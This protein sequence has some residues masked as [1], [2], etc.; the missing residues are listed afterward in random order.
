MSKLIRRKYK[1]PVNNG[2]HKDIP[3]QVDLVNLT[4]VKERTP[5]TKAAYATYHLPVEEEVR[6]V[7]VVMRNQTKGSHGTLNLG[8]KFLSLKEIL[9][10]SKMKTRKG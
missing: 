8:G 3:F 6:I 2:S 1:R 5:E 10:K 7:A 9:C 4:R